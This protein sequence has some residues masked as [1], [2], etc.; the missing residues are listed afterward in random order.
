[1]H[2]MPMRFLLAIFPRVDSTQKTPLPAHTHAFQPTHTR[3]QPTHPFQPHTRIPAHIHAFQPTHT[4]LPA[5]THTHTPSSP[6]TR[7][8]AHIHAFQPTYT[9]SGPHTHL[10]AHT[11]TPSGP[12]T[13][14]SPHTRGEKRINDNVDIKTYFPKQTNKIPPLVTH[15]FSLQKVI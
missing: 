7:L 5:H 13:P 14:S 6:H 8:P 1:V 2:K 4:R 15:D 3:L 10:P 12:H 11:H 9:P